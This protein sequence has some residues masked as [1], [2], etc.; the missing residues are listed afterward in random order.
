MD[1]PNGQVLNK[2]TAFPDEERSKLGLHGL[3]PP[4][5]RGPWQQA[6]RAYGACKRKDDD[7]KRHV[8]LRALQDANDSP[9]STGFYSTTLKKWP[10]KHI[11]NLDGSVSLASPSMRLHAG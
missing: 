5:N 1:L 10:P 2:G 7:L 11:D 9:V 4:Y 6:V 3:L 8:Y